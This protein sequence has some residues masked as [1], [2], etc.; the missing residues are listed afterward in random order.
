MK[1]YFWL[2]LL[3]VSTI[4]SHADSSLQYKWYPGIVHLHTTYSDGIRS[5]RDNVTK[6][7]NLGLKFIVITDHASYMGEKEENFT[8][9]MTTRYERYKAEAKSFNQPDHFAVFSSLEVSAKWHAE[10]DTTDTA[11]TIGITFGTTH[12]DPI[13]S[14][15]DQKEGVQAKVIKRFNSL[16]CLP[17]AAHPTLIVTK[18]FDT[19][20]WRWTRMRYDRRDPSAYEGLCGIEFFNCT[21]DEQNE[22]IVRWYLS[23]IKEGRNIFVTSGCDSHGFI[24]TDSLDSERW[25]RVTWVLSTLLNDECLYWG[26]QKGMTYAACHGFSIVDFTYCPGFAPQKMST[27]MINFT[28]KMP[29][30]T[31]KLEAFIY[32]DGEKI[33]GMIGASEYDGIRYK[34]EDT[35]ATPGI[36]RYVFEIPNRLITS[37]IVIDVR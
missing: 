18:S 13:M 23:L 35:K 5:M 3:T 10:P 11:D 20:P 37:P 6:A 9:E 1:K 31:K 7:K 28:V 32:R 17:I 16:S 25:K 36:H 30:G 14:D 22:E 21:T 12:W 8:G 26:I 4:T 34:F 27:S 15:L 19:K 2:V 24:S 29:K 33:V